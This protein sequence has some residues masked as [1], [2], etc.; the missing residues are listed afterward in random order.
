MVKYNI[1]R[2][3]RRTMKRTYRKR[4]NTKLTI[5]RYIMNNHVFIKRQ[6]VKDTVGATVSG[7]WTSFPFI[8]KFNDLTSYPE[9]LLFDSYKIH[10][11]KLTFTPYWD[12]NDLSNQV[13]YTTVLPRVYTIVD[14]NGFPAGSLAT[15]NQFLEHAKARQIRRPQEP[16]SIYIKNPGVETSAA[17]GGGFTA[18]GLTRYSPWIDTSNVNIEH[19]GCALG[20]ILPGGSPTAGFYYN[21]V[22][23]YYMHFK[24]AV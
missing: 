6:F 7:G 15:E 13:N 22:A 12:S 1:K 14:R 2:R 10:A 9:M 18:N 3:S 4:R 23:T 21:V 5:P 11:I 24:N 16:F 8:F 20:M 17:T 19:F